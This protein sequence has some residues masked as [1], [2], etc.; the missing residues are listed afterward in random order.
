MAYFIFIVSRA[1]YRST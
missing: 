1:R